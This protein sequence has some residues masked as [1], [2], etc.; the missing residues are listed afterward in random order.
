MLD[1]EASSEQLE[2]RVHLALLVQ[3]EPPVHW[4]H[5]ECREKEAE[6]DRPVLWV[7]VARPAM[8]VNQVLWVQ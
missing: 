7:N 6:L 1:Q 5:P 8:L 2:Q 3:W 4:G